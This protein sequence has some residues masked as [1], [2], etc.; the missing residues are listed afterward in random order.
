MIE[1]NKYK[2]V[3]LAGLLHDIGKFYGR[4]KTVKGLSGELKEE[5]D[6]PSNHPIISAFFVER[7]KEQI[8]ELGLDFDV[9]KTLVQRH[10]E[11]TLMPKECLVQETKDSEIRALAYLVSKADNYSSSE[12]GEIEYKGQKYAT[13][14]MNSVFERIDIGLGETDIGYII[15]PSELSDPSNIFPEKQISTYQPNFD[16]LVENF[17]M[18]VSRLKADNFNDLYN[19]LLA[20][21]QRFCWAIPSDIR[22]EHRD[23]SLFDH[24][25]TTSAIAAALYKYHEESLSEKEINSQSEEKFLLI[26]GDLSGIQKYL[27]GIATIDAGKVAKKLRARSFR[28]AMLMEAT[29]ILLCKE[30]D[31]PISSIIISTGGRFVLLMPNTPETKEK[32]KEVTFK[33]ESWLLQEYKGELSIN[34]TTQG[35]TPDGFKIENF[36]KVISELN[37]KFE[38]KKLNKFS[39]VLNENHVFDEFKSF[40]EN[41]D[42]VSCSSCGKN[43]IAKNEVEDTEEQ[44]ERNICDKSKKDGEIGEFL[45]RLQC[46]S[47]GFS[48]NYIKDEHSLVFYDNVFVSLNKWQKKPKGTFI[49]Y[50]LDSKDFDGCLIKYIA[51]YVPRAK[52]ENDKLLEIGNIDGAVATFEEIASRAEGSKHLGILKADVDRL[53]LIFSEGLK[54]ERALTISRISTLSFQLDAFFSGYLPIAIKNNLKESLQEDIDKTYIVYSGGDD[55]LFVGPWDSIFGLSKFI[56]DKFAKFT[57]NNP[58]I[59]ISAGIAITHNKHPVWDGAKRAD[60]LLEL[61]KDGMDQKIYDKHVQQCP[62]CNSSNKCKR[63]RDSLTVF[64]T[65]IKWHEFEEIEKTASLLDGALEGADGLS[66]G[67]VYSLLTFNRMKKDHNPMYKALLSYQIARNLSKEKIE[68]NPQLEKAREFLV[69]LTKSEKENFM[70]KINIPVSYALLKNRG[71]NES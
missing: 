68:N 64:N 4:S 59:S 10:H 22:E 66:T 39:E 21:I 63:E 24:L 61:S 40:G 15:K 26:G 28:I 11:Y 14:L 43:L 57:C 36:C 62:S 1:I 18:Q 45:P 32:L 71:G 65:T 48:E 5:S 55:L 2:E 54:K 42:V 41:D 13:S 30:F 58:N 3:I 7:L 44:E 25:K 17:G 19:S 56:R 12:R 47:I 33:I 23:V 49:T 20:L 70:E 9:V 38:E 60:E 46:L 29:S 50:S 69:S 51:N 35:F 53:G 31:L 6:L 27:Y 16:K 52:K 67:F 34:I 37:A 8:V